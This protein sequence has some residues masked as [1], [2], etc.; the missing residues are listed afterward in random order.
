VNDS[1]SQTFDAHNIGS[2]VAG[3]FLNVVTNP[4]TIVSHILVLSPE[5]GNSISFGEGVLTVS[6]VDGNVGIDTLIAAAD[7]TVTTTMNLTVPYGKAGTDVAFIGTMDTDV[8]VE[9]VANYS[10][11]GSPPERTYGVVYQNTTGRELKVW[12]W[13]AGDLRVGSTT[14]VSELDFNLGSGF[15]Y[16]PVPKDW[17]YMNDYDNVPS[18]WIEQ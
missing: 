12:V 17:Y 6:I 9:L 3:A 16:A 2:P 15:V 7:A 18:G 13:G 5:S 8:S 4:G 14:D 1:R 11:T 10:E